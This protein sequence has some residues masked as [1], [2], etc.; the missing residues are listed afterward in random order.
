MFKGGQHYYESVSTLCTGMP[1]FANDQRT[2]SAK[3][4]K[5]NPIWLVLTWVVIELHL[6]RVVIWLLGIFLVVSFLSFEVVSW[7]A[8]WMVVPFWSFEVFS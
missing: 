3:L 8:I 4:F 7:V 6:I 1:T 5:W 2:S